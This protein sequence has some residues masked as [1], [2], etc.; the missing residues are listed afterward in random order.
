MCYISL[1][2]DLSKRHCCSSRTHMHTRTYARTHVLNWSELSSRLCVAYI[3]CDLFL[4]LI[5]T[6]T[7]PYVRT[8][9]EMMS[10]WSIFLSHC[11]DVWTVHVHVYV[12]FW[13]QHTVN[14]CARRT[15]ESW[16]L[17][18]CVQVCMH[19]VYVCDIHTAQHNGS[20]LQLHV[21]ERRHIW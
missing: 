1:A 5:H 8:S 4:C 10:V 7:H 6:H 11:L 3:W 2:F 18:D 9:S 15:A 17:F 13:D 19:W 20:Q 14:E 16:I 12:L 21:K